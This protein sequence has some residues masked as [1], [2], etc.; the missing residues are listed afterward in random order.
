MVL[1]SLTRK[2]LVAIV[3]VFLN[4]NVYD[5]IGP[6]KAIQLLFD[7]KLFGDFLRHDIIDNN[8][9]EENRSM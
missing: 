9:E 6:N 4:W 8:E 5:F 3:I 1:T 7:R 2:L